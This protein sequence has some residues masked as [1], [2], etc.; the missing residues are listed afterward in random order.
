MN[1]PDRLASLPAP[2]ALV[3]S[4]GGPRGAAQAGAIVELIAVG[5]R[6]D[7]VVGTS[8]GALN[9]AWVA[10]HP[11][12]PGGLLDVWRGPAVRSVFRGLLVNAFGQAIV[13]RR[14]PAR[15]RRD[16]ALSGD[17]LRRILLATMRH[18]SFEEVAGA[19]VPLVAGAVDLLTGDLVYIDSGELVDALLG[20]A[21]LPGILPPVR[22]EGRLLSDGGSADNFGVEEAARRLGGRGSVV[23]IDASVGAIEG[24]PAGMA[25]IVE[26]ARDIGRLHQRRRAV[27][28]AL[29][30]GAACEV[31]E[32]GGRDAGLSAASISRGIGAGRR[33]AR[34][35]LG[36][37]PLEPEAEPLEPPGGLRRGVDFIEATIDSAAQKLRRARGGSS[38]A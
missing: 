32:V 15:W 24:A 8:I 33:V 38:A 37:P 16:A 3:L 25:A 28:A 1:P 12:D 14:G 30:H 19:G 20:S 6:P 22:R 23:L 18:R 35:W 34:Q 10:A 29:V 36:L 5:F 26:R 17:R 21:A 7:L 4:G 27:H 9:G 11:G 2:R 31:I 13:D